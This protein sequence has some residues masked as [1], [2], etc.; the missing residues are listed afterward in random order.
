MLSIEQKKAISDFINF[1]TSSGIGWDESLWNE[2]EEL[3]IPKNDSPLS[4]YSYYK[5]LK[6]LPAETKRK[7]LQIIILAWNDKKDKD[8]Y[9]SCLYESLQKLIYLKICDV[10]SFHFIN[11]FWNLIAY[12]DGF[13]DN[14]LYIESMDPDWY[15]IYISGGAIR[16]S[17]GDID[18]SIKYI[19][20]NMDGDILEENFDLSLGHD[21]ALFNDLYDRLLEYA[22]KSHCHWIQYK[23]SLK[24]TYHYYIPALCIEVNNLEYLDT[25]GVQDDICSECGNFHYDSWR[26]QYWCRLWNN[27]AEKDGTCS[28][29]NEDYDDLLDRGIHIQRNE[30]Y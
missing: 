12:F 4:L 6:K 3:E 16:M 19:E 2:F 25:N 11:L 14:G 20:I 5:N 21:A 24:A 15:T 1:L 7:I 10:N 17:M 9:K 30:D 8:L 22:S 28:Y 27:W 13:N 26:S 23:A 29:F 18:E